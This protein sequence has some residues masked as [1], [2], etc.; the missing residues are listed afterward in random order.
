VG[1]LWRTASK[2]NLDIL[3]L[4][5]DLTR[6]TPAI[7]WRNQECPSFLERA[8][9]GF[10]LVMMLAVVHHMLVTERIPLEDLLELADD[11][12]R[13]YVLIELVAPPDP[14]FQHIVRGRDELYSHISPAWFETAALSRFELVRS[15]RIDGL[16]RWLYLFR[17][18]RATS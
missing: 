15:A 18:R 5:V 4:V 11:L 6:P 8:R 10:D 17:R 2:E 7:G 3:P 14:K 13:G 12:S 1:A 16:S 9:G